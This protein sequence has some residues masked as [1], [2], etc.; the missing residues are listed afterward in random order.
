M[1]TYVMSDIHGCYDEF[2]SML[3]KIGF[4][5]TD[6]LI[7][8]GDYID[9]GTQ[10]YEMLKWIEQWSPNILLLRGN[11]EEEF[12]EYVDLMCLL[13][14]SEELETDFDSN[15]DT[16]AL[17]ESVKYFI[18][19]KASSDSYFD[20]YRTIDFLLSQCRVTL[21]DL[22]RWTSVIRQMPYYHKVMFKD[23]IYVIVN[24]GGQAQGLPVSV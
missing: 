12:A 9:R 19:H 14:H 16:V 18:G 5:D 6:R 22:C 2:L 7:M 11:H 15:A 24:A 3:K 8:A 4:S 20:L 10:S 1:N 13:N 17:Y 21:S 23:R